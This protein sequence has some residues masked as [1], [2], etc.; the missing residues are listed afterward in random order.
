MLMPEGRLR[1]RRCVGPGQSWGISHRNSLKTR[2]ESSLFLSLSSFFFFSSLDIW[3]WTSLR[4]LL[5]FFLRFKETSF[6]A[7]LRHIC[8]FSASQ[9]MS[10]ISPWVA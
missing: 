2:N 8:C 5:D 6:P 7:S 4:A 10:G 9:R 1:V 3:F